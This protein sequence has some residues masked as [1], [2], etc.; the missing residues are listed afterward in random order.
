M[1][2][3]IQVPERISFGIPLRDLRTSDQR[4]GRC[5]RGRSRS[6]W[7][8]IKIHSLARFSKL[9]NGVSRRSQGS[10][11]DIGTAFEWTWPVS[12]KLLQAKGGSPA[13]GS[14]HPLDHVLTVSN[15]LIQEVAESRQSIKTQFLGTNRY[16]WMRSRSVKH[17]MVS[18]ATERNRAD[19]FLAYRKV[20]ME[21]FGSIWIAVESVNLLR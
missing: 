12:S 3:A 17:D 7:N 16:S 11:R 8:R 4:T 6:G 14:T 9:L 10:A 20:D 5:E 21:S 2:K 15:F 19:G 1:A 18:H 13:L